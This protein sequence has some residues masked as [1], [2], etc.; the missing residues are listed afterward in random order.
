MTFQ[1]LHGSLQWRPDSP[2]RDIRDFYARVFGKPLLGLLKQ[3][4]PS[5]RKT[6]LHNR[7]GY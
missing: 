4:F 2:A 1:Q 6:S 3:V 7:W 5:G